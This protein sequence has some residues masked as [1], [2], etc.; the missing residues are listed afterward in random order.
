MHWFD[1]KELSLRTDA[2][3]GNSLKKSVC[4]IILYIWGGKKKN[5]IKCSENREQ[6]K[7][8]IKKKR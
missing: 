7:L 4:L 3:G 2:I 5:Q 1:D 6:G 8:K